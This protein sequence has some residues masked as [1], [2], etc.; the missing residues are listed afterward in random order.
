[1]RTAFVITAS[2]SLSRAKINDLAACDVERGPLPAAKCD[3]HSM[4]LPANKSRVILNVIKAAS[5]W[6]SVNNL[7]TGDSGPCSA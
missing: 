5:L 4:A 7:P 2:M 3:M 1:M 6:L